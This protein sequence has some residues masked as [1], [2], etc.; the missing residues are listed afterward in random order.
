MEHVAIVRWYRLGVGSLGVE[1]A[2]RELADR[3]ETIYGDSATDGPGDGPRVICRVELPADGTVRVSF[4]DPEPLDEARFIETVFPDRGYLSRVDDGGRLVVRLPG[5]TDEVTLSGGALTAPAATRWQPLVANLAVSRVLRLQRSMIF[6]HAASLRI[7]GRGLLACGP[8]RSGKTT[9]TLGLA[10]RGHGLLGD[11]IAAL[12]TGSRELLPFRRS[13]AM[14][15]GPTS[16][17]ASALLAGTGGVSERF[18]DG[19][20]RTRLVVR[21]ISP[22]LPPARTPLTTVV[23][24]RS[25]VPATQVRRV[26][27]GPAML[28][29][30]TPLAASLWDRSPALVAMQLLRTFAGTQVFEIDSGPPDEVA[31][32][33]EA[34]MEE[35]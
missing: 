2:D 21:R 20:L 13:V 29:A 16:T 22:E 31:D 3:F 32:R 34:L 11:E 18:P 4:D 1:S 33:I 15:E 19:E 28:G 25:I 17:G 27:V 10:A 23:I 7:G 24:L 5:S 35:R 26:P 8:K 6:F 9:L 12:D 30:L 14:R